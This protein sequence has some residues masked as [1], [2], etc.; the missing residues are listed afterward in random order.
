LYDRGGG[1]DE[2]HRDGD[3]FVA[4][5][6]AEREQNDAQRVGPVRD[7]DGALDAQKFGEFLLELFDL[8]AAD[9]SAKGMNLLEFESNTLTGLRGSARPNLRT[10]FLLRPPLFQRSCA[11][12]QP[13]GMTR[14]DRARRHVTND[15]C[16]RSN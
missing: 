15:H 7:T 9:I 11:P 10:L 2:C 5:A 16:A 1:R 13:C 6:G 14:Y 12:A 4:W 3:H 8:M